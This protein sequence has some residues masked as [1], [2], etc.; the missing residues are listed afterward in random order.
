[1]PKKFAVLYYGNI[2]V[3]ELPNEENNAIDTGKVLLTKIGQ[4]LMSIC[5]S[6]PVDGFYGYICEKWT[7]QGYI[8]IEGAPEKPQDPP[9]DV[10]A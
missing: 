4:E 7:S 3:L 5:G 8:K 10:D 1:L 6:R 2:T 9:F